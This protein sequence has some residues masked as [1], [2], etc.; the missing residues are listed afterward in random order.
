MPD[1]S[2]G[3]AWSSSGEGEGWGSSGASADSPVWGS[4]VGCPVGAGAAVAVELPL[5]W[6]TVPVWGTA[7]GW[8]V[9]VPAAAELWN[10]EPAWL[11]PLPVWLLLPPVWPG[12]E[13][14]LLSTVRVTSPP[15]AEVVSPLP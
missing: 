3:A 8:A 10:W 9:T 6:L 4:W 15:D 1:L 5:P 7:V 13:P 2:S 14:E 12:W 11:L